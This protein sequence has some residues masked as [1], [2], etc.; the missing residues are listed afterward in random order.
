MEQSTRKRS[1]P[2]GRHGIPHEVVVRD[3]R[4]R[5]LE[6]MIRVASSKGYEAATVADV[7][8]AAGVSRTTFYQLFK[9]KE[10]CFLASYD[11]VVDVLVQ[12]VQSAYRGGERP[13]PER[14]HSGLAALVQLLSQEAEIA[15]MAMVEVIAAG[16]AARQRYRDALGRFTPFLDE[17]RAWSDFGAMLPVSTSRL[18]IGGAAALLFD[19]IRAGHGEEL[20]QVL[21]DLVF[22]VLMP[23]IGPEAASAEMR[24]ELD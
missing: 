1:L 2:S 15:N 8:E 4:E 21:P 7:I 18:A 23:F 3:Q 10:D 9:D 19:E 24:R 17:G 5:L 6:A 20:E 12:Y 11:A 22:A 14:I 13:W 16:P